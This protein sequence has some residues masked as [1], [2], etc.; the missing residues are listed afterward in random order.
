MSGSSLGSGLTGTPIANLETVLAYRHP[1][2]VA[3]YIKDFGD[4][5]TAAEELF[6]ELLR[7]LY[8]CARAT[9]PG[10]RAGAISMYPEILRIDDMWHVFILH[11]RDYADFCDRYFGRFIHHEPLPPDAPRE[12]D[13]CEV[14]TELEAFLSL[15]YDELGEWTV[16]RWFLER[17]YA[18][19]DIPSETR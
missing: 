18:K 15:L 5:Q 1:G 4:D 14:N 8:Y 17:R 9:E 10:K 19:G 16:R 12:R 11:T 7:W 13:Q 6:L 2:V 3:R